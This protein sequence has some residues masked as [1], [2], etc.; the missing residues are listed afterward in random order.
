MIPYGKGR[1]AYVRVPR[2]YIFAPIRV[3][4]CVAPILHHHSTRATAPHRNGKMKSLLVPILTA[5]A[6][7]GA[8]TLAAVWYVVARH[9]IEAP[10]VRVLRA[11]FGRGRNTTI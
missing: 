11:M 7:L 6:T 3:F 5:F 2:N 8:L 4:A 1:E 10:Q 9:G